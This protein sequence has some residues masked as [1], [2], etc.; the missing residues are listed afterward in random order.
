MRRFLALLL[1]VLLPLQSAWAATASTWDH[2]GTS[3][4]HGVFAQAHQDHCDGLASTD[5]LDADA[6]VTPHLECSHG[7][8]HGHFT[9]V[10]TSWACVSSFAERSFAAPRETVEQREPTSSRPERPQWPGRV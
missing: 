1:I 2:H 10:P 8:C 5:P 7:H 3:P 6:T 9:A 4:D